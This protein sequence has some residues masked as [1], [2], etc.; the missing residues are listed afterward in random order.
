M[1]PN[2]TRALFTGTGKDVERFW[3]PY[4]LGMFGGWW[5]GDKPGT[6]LFTGILTGFGF[7]L[8]FRML[9][10]Y[11]IIQEVEKANADGNQN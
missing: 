11:R 10:N 9:W 4:S 6:L 8:M 3:L 5:N 7:I 2:Y 1:K